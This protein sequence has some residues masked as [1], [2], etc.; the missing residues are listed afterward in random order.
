VDNFV[1]RTILLVACSLLVGR[2]HAQ[3][4][5]QPDVVGLKLGMTVARAEAVLQKLQPGIW[6]VTRYATEDPN[7]W[8]GIGIAPQMDA[9]MSNNH[10]FH[11]AALHIPI[12]LDA[13][14]IDQAYA[15]EGGSYAA[16]SPLKLIQDQDT[17]VDQFSG[18]FFSLFFT[19]TDDGGRLYAIVRKK[20]YISDD[21]R[22]L[23]F[24]T[25]AKVALP[26]ESDL[27][28]GAIDKY[29]PPS[30][31]PTESDHKVGFSASLYWLYDH[32]GGKLATSV[33]PQCES[34][35]A[36][37]DGWIMGAQP[38]DY[39][40]PKLYSNKS[41]GVLT[42]R[43][44]ATSF[45][46][47]DF[48]KLGYHD[49]VT[50]LMENV[51]KIPDIFVPVMVTPNGRVAAWTFHESPYKGC[52]TQVHVVIS[53]V[54]AEGPER[55]LGYASALTVSLSQQESVFFDNGVAAYMKTKVDAMKPAAL[56]NRK[57]ERY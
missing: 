41:R 30:E 52:G 22:P 5:A 25:K 35:F 11:D 20:I 39:T 14:Y 43:Q 9:G 10:P 56:E 24:Y 48:Y 1:S 16:G 51:S 32:D 42:L 55:H 37:E 19:P 44:L 38:A 47:R 4:L 49:T 12:H 18:E 21:Q 46:T 6:M 34:S 53:P 13:G 28:K 23:S 8:R 40:P 2:G 50:S 29:G 54:P 31:P 33:H 26:R 17:P 15:Q 36:G 57:P 27:E 7:T 45:D 3:G